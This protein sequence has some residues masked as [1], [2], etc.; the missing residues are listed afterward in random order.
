MTDTIVPSD[1]IVTVE[2]THEKVTAQAIYFPHTD[3][4]RVD[5][6]VRRP[7][8]WLDVGTGF[9]KDDK[10]QGI[11]AILP[12]GLMDTLSSELSKKIG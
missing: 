7:G 2:I 5:V 10:I 6:K 1:F 9:W 3:Q 11:S 12:D 4:K 8:L